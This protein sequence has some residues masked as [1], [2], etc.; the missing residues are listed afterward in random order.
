MT[1]SLIVIAGTFGLGAFHL[2]WYTRVVAW[3]LWELSGGIRQEGRL[4]QFGASDWSWTVPLHLP[5][6]LLFYAGLDLLALLLVPGGSLVAGFAASSL[7]VAVVCRERP[8]LGRGWWRLWLFLAGWAWAP[9]PAAVSLIY[10]WT[11]VY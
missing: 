10:Q 7:A 11:V 2:L 1:R 3:W 5:A 9:V 8:L 4:T 6:G